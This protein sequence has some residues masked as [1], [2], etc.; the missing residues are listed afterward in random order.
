M[1]FCISNFNKNQKI[2]QN[3][4]SRMHCKNNPTFLSHKTKEK[5]KR[6]I[7][8]SKI[9]QKEQTLPQ[10]IML[11]PQVPLNSY[12]ERARQ[13][14]QR[15]QSETTSGVILSAIKA[16]TQLDCSYKTPEALTINQEALSNWRHFMSLCKRLR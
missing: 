8:N 10:V 7:L 13:R 15:T 3:R 6:Y 4:K 5:Q 1:L 11:R 2:N 14:G 16:L 12:Q 9:R